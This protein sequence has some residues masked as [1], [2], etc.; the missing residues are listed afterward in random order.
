MLTVDHFEI[1][2][3]KVL[4]DGESQ[5]EVARELG[6]SRKTVAKALAHPTP[7]GYRGS[8]ARKSP[9]M[10][11]VRSI[12]EAWLEA[13][14]TAPPKQRHTAARIF[15]RLRDEHQFKGSESTVR[16][17]VAGL[18]TQQPKEAYMP[19][20]FDP[21]EE[22]QVDWGEAKVIQNGIEGTVQLFCVR[23]AH[24]KASFVYPYERATME[25]FL[26]GHVRALAFF[27]GVPRR[28]A[29][30][31]LKSA[32]VYVG[33]GRHRQ[34]NEHFK[35]LRSHYLF[36]TRFCNVASG[37]EKGDVENQV[38]RSQRTYLTPVPQVTS[39]VEL[40]E[41]LEGDCRRDL[42]KVDDRQTQSRG[43]LL[44]RERT[45]FV[46][47]PPVAFQACRE[48]ATHVSKQLLV[49]FDGNDYSTP[50]EHA[51]RPCV[52]RGYVDRVEV[53]VNHERVATH[54]RSYG[55]GEFVL[56]PMHFVKLLERKPGSLDNA[57]PFKGDP[58]GPDLRAMRTELEYRQ[59]DGAGTKQFIRILQLALTHPIDT[60][61]RAVAVC[62][63]RRAYGVAAVVNVLNNEPQRDVPRLDLSHRAELCGVGSGVRSLSIYDQLTLEAGDETTCQTPV[64]APDHRLAPPDHRLAPPDHRLAP[65]DHRLAPI[66]CAGE[67]AEVLA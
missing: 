53:Q 3:R 39:M 36:E 54:P 12:I 42:E 61:R 62:V 34:L 52:V 45:A 40:A 60:V 63:S 65:P 47:L 13:D 2:R 7:P 27:G 15:E 59:P 30:D 20:A 46:P 18:K 23:L 1:I 24:S 50:T 57:R 35:Q 67:L 29:Y 26:D 55:K 38:K 16:R 44:E 66:D 22:G 10:D 37:N 49:R 6:H 8:K 43:Q 14:K 41:K 21:G 31:N 4:L 17:F 33:K 28:L 48:E 9:V 32:V 19:L 58:W 51:Q 5:R 25:A 11:P 56:E 64:E